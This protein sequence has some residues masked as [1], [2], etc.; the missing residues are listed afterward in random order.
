LNRS[1]DTRE[2]NQKNK[3]RKKSIKQKSEPVTHK[4]T[5]KNE[6]RLRWGGGDIAIAEMLH[7]GGTMRRWTRGTRRQGTG[8]IL[9]RGSRGLMRQEGG[10]VG[11]AE[12]IK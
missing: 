6:R 4:H 7:F 11:A 8:V 10:M 12:K 5:A 9:V 3:L 2:N 1:I